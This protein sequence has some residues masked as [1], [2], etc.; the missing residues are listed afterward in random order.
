MP[1]DSDD[2]AVQRWDAG[3]TGCGELVMELRRRLAPLMPGAM[4][5]LVAHDPGAPADIPSWCRMTGHTLVAADH[6][7]YLIQRRLKE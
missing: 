6:P 2:S 3:Q 4:F 5:E 1:A 7:V